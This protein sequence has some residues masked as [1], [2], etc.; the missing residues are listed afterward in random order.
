MSIPATTAAE[1]ERALAAFARE[2]D[3]GL[4][5]LP[6]PSTITHRE[7]L[8]AL[9][10]RHRLPAIYSNRVSVSL[11]GMMCYTALPTDWRQVTSYVDR[12]LKGAKPVISRSRRRR[13][14]NW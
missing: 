6:G 10:L 13:N 9:A 3:G 2:A 1:V 4:M 14:M 12:I 5:V 8:V 7:L 11:G